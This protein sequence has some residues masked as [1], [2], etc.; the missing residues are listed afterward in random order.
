MSAPT[1]SPALTTFLK[2]CDVA[3][4]VMNPTPIQ[5]KTHRKDLANELTRIQGRHKTTTGL[6]LLIEDLDA[7]ALRTG[8]LLAARPPLIDEPDDISPNTPNFK[9]RYMEFLRKEK[10]YTLQNDTE[11]GLRTLLHKRYH[12]ILKSY[13]STQGV[14]NPKYRASELFDIIEKR[15]CTPTKLATARNKIQQELNNLTYRPNPKGSVPYFST[16]DRLNNELK[17]LGG[18]P[19]ATTTRIDRFNDLFATSNHTPATKLAFT[20]N[21]L[22]N[23]RNGILD[24]SISID[25]AEDPAAIYSR[26]KVYCNEETEKMYNLGDHGVSTTA[27]PSL[28]AQLSDLTARHEALVAEQQAYIAQSNANF[29][30][31]SANLT[32]S[33]PPPVPTTITTQPSTIAT[34]TNPAGQPKTYKQFNKYCWSCGININHHTKDHRPN[35][36]RKKLP[37]HED[38]HSCTYADKQGGS[39]RNDHYY[40]WWRCNEDGNHYQHRP[41]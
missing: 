19:S 34:V 11:L 40:M 29:D 27:N 6:C 22:I 8:K 9:A 32:T 10:I 28:V 23:E 16:L 20:T 2:K 37:G 36:K 24:E 1:E 17:R 39:T 38:H 25:E 30:V 5:V 26:Y 18:A 41:N 31:L 4:E 12:S 3:Q 21:W 7:Y 35:Y 33:A 14:L 13:E 15:V